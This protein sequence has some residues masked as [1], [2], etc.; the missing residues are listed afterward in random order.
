[1]ETGIPGRA[2]ARAGDALLGNLFLAGGNANIIGAD[3]AARAGVRISWRTHARAGVP[4][5]M[6]P[7][8]PAAQRLWNR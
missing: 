4:A 8:G 6:I 2:L 5:T 7:P 3:K 1:V